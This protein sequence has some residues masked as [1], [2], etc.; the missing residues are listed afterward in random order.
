MS[1]NHREISVVKGMLARG[2]KQQDIAAYFGV[3]GGRISEIN[4]GQCE[5]AVGVGPAVEADLPPAGPIMAGR[6]ALH[7]RD[8][9][10]ALRNDI[11]RVLAEIDD[12][13]R[14]GK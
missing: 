13:E 14:G 12:F 10:R 1:L 9:L 4:T 6:S 8:T 11:D 7:M 2:D 3:N 5:D